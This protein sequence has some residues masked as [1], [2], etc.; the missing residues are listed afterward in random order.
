LPGLFSDASHILDDFSRVTMPRNTIL[1][2]TE[3]KA[4]FNRHQA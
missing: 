2:A 4:L 1:T 3:K